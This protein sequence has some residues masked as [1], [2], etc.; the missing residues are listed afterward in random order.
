LEFGATRA[1]RVL[2]RHSIKCLRFVLL[3][4]FYGFAKRLHLSAVCRYTRAFSAARPFLAIPATELSLYAGIQIK[5]QVQRIQKTI[6][7]KAKPTNAVIPA[8]ER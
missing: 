6:F 2:K 4:A 7:N 3:S 5:S 8:T 1:G